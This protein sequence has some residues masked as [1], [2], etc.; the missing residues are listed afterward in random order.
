[1]KKG[2]EPLV[3][4]VA[5]ALDALGEHVFA[6]P[7]PLEERPGTGRMSSPSM[8]PSVAGRQKR[9]ALIAAFQLV[10]SLFGAL[11]DELGKGI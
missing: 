4:R 3:E 9:D 8:R 10:D 6:I 7:N 5:R 11:Q 2:I 1:M